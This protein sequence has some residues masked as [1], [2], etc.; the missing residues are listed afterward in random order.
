MAI[1]QS[2]LIPISDFFLSS[3]VVTIQQ[4]DG[5]AHKLK[6]RSFHKFAHL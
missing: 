6:S 3:E 2:V 1:Y 5:T 4:S